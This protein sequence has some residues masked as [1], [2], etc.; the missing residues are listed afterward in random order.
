MFAAVID[1]RYSRKMIVRARVVVTMDGPPVD[2]GAVR[3]MNGRIAEAGKIS[4]VA[5]ANDEILDLGE[6]VLLPGLI[7]AHCHLDYT[8]LRR[9]ILPQKSFTDWIQAINAKKSELSPKDYVA[10]ITEGF[11]EAARFGATAIANLTAFP[12][13]ISQIQPPI[14]TCWF[15][16]LIDIREPER[17]NE[18]VDS[19]IEA[20]KQT[21][22]WGLAPHA[23]FT[24]SKDLF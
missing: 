17:A 1:R 8:C 6:Q 21:P 5:P 12:E 16:E 18:F 14:R 23:L 22:S 7:N 24:A 10:S 20:L 4:E 15:A 2:D 9:K 19:A 13:L 3:V 11:A